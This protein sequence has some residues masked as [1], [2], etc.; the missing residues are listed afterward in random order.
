MTPAYERN[1][2]PV[3]RDDFYRIACDP[4]RHVV[5]EAC[6]GAGK[7]V[8]IRSGVGCPSIGSY[9]LITHIIGHDQNEVGLFLGLGEKG[10]ESQEKLGDDKNE[11][12]HKD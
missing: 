2:A 8:Q 4:Q 11:F 10:K 7:F 5:V 12:F 9:T 6:A 3:A 1:G